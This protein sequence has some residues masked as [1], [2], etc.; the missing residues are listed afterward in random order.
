L[1]IPGFD[2]RAVENG[3]RALH[4]SKSS[5]PKYWSASESDVSQGTLDTNHLHPVEYVKKIV[6]LV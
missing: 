1:L 4:S 3:Y 6:R 5:K 2:V